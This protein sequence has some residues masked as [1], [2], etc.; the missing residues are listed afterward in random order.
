MAIRTAPGVLAVKVDYRSQ[1]AAIGTEAGSVVPKEQVLAALE[2]IGY[3]G[4]FVEP[5]APTRPLSE[6]HLQTSETP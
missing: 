5:H 4:E 3:R 1:Q 2:S 6:S